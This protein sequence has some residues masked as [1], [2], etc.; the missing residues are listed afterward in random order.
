LTIYRLEIAYDGSGFRGYA[1]QDGQRSV[2]SELEEALATY[3]KGAVTTSV[4]GRT[5]AGVHARA[6]VV[7]FAYDG[8]VDVERLRRGLD[9]LFGPEISLRRVDLA[10]DGFNARFSARWRRYRYLL[11]M[12][13]S[14]D[15]LTRGFVWHVGRSLDGAAM[16]RAAGVFVGEHDFSAFCR[17]ME[18]KSNKRRVTELSLEEEGEA[19]TIWIQANAF[20]HQMVRSIVGYLYDVGRGFCDGAQVEDVIASGDRSRVATVA[21]PHGLTLWEVGY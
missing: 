15:P 3:L 11:D 4:A 16:V 21:P 1:R 18:G 9:G 17:S 12:G 10:P 19:L 2:Q 20:C 13:V 14:A 6:Q 7:S 8:D 5:D